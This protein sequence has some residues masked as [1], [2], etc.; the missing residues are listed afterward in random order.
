[1]GSSMDLLG[2]VIYSIKMKNQNR[3]S[4]IISNLAFFCGQFLLCN[5]TVKAKDLSAV[6]HTSTFKL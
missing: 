6:S 3:M 4:Y 5:C 1:M 2:I